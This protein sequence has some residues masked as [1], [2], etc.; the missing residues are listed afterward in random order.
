MLRNLDLY[1]VILA[2]KYQAANDVEAMKTEIARL[3]KEPAALQ[4]LREKS[5]QISQEY[6]EERLL[7]IWL[8]FYREQA[9][10]GKSEGKR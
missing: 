9:K 7:Q 6:S 5:H 2:G 1:K 8:A 4:D 3:K 10:L